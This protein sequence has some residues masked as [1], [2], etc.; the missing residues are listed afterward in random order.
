MALGDLSG[1]KTYEDWQKA[2]RAA[3]GP[4][5][6]NEVAGYFNSG[7]ASQQAP[8]ANWAPSTEQQNTARQRAGSYSDDS[9]DAGNWQTG[10]PYLDQLRSGQF[11]Q[12]EDWR[13]MSNPQL[14]AWEQYYIGNGKFRNKYGDIVDKPDD[15][16]P[17]TPAGYNGT[18]DFLG[19]GGGGGGGRGG[20]GGGG[21]SYGSSSGSSSSGSNYQYEN[22]IYQY[23]KGRYME[24][25][26]NPDSALKTFM[27]YGGQGEY[28][29]QMDAL[30][31]QVEQ[32]P[33]GPAREAAMARLQEQRSTGLSSM[34][35]DA[36]KQANDRLNSLVNPEYQYAGLG[37]DIWSTGLQD[38]QYYAGL[39]ENARQAN[40]SNALGWG[41]LNLGRDQFNYNQNMGWANFGEGQRQFD[42]NMG[43]N[44]WQQEGNWGNAQN[45][46][47][48]QQ[49]TGAQ[50]WLNTAG[51][52]AGVA[53]GL[54]DLWKQ[55]KSNQQS[56]GGKV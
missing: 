2:N 16:G 36:S 5:E 9:A 15:V 55:W 51:A 17:N 53:G 37:K 31:Q 34:K 33:P 21:G 38:K 52:A 3:G 25:V 48:S 19:H 13:R 8:Q 54:S 1:F 28:Q 6:S 45:A 26:Q 27:G 18:G 23:L 24:D 14:K 39:G 32:L 41:N 44:R 35:A 12:S 43:F 56:A 47:N 46:L 20:A 7:G 49:P 42:Q 40:M 10:D 11:A 29:Q 50:K 4:G 22:P 30:Q